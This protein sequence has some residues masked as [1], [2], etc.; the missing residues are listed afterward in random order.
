MDYYCSLCLFSSPLACG[1]RW[2]RERKATLLSSGVG[3]VISQYEKERK[4]A[5]NVSKSRTTLEISLKL[6]REVVSYSFIFVSMCAL[7]SF[8]PFL[9]T[10]AF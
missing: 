6:L 10:L 2:L 1:A 3:W 4:A 5:A 8:C 7:L 9:S